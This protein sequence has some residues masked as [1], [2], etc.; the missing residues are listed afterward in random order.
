MPHA[1]LSP[2]TRTNPLRSLRAV[3]A[4]PHLDLVIPALNEEGRIER[5]IEAISTWAEVSSHP[6]NLI[7]VDNGSADATTECIDRA[8]AH[9]LSVDV[10]SCRVRGKGAAV[11]AGVLRSRAPFVGYCDADLATPLTAIDPALRLLAEGWDVVLGSR[12]CE[13]A[14][15]AVPQTLIRRSGSWCFRRIAQRYVGTIADTQCGFKVFSGPAARSIFSAT[16]LTGFAFDVEIVA[17]ALR[18]GYR[19]VELPVEWSDQ[20]GSTFRPL[21]DGVS[22]FRDLAGLRR[23]LALSA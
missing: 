4:Q 7:V 11:R 21:R 8:S 16:E 3:P 20:E 1:L 6:V 14:S 17:R 22:S 2:P 9:H 23:T 13:G 19:V 12:L 10:V 5:T 18:S 15:Y